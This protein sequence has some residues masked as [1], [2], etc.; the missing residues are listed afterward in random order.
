MATLRIEPLHPTL[1]AMPQHYS[2]QNMPD[3]AASPREV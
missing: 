3:G 1:G 2:Q